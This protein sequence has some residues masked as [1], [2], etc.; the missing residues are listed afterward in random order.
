MTKPSHTCYTVRPRGEGNKA[1]WA[2][3][4][5]AW[6]NHDGS[7]NISLDAMPLDGKIVLRL[8]K[9]NENDGTDQAEAA[10]ATA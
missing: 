5:S 9:D 3:I 6:V 8:R 1:F 10:E 4:G 7:F 2:R